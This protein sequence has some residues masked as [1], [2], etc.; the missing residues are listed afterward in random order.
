MQFQPITDGIDIVDW[1]VPL[2]GGDLTYSIWD[3]A[4][5]SVY[6]NTHQVLQHTSCITK[7]QILQQI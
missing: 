3:F 4:G 6:Y 5:Q 7:H 2:Q 1:R